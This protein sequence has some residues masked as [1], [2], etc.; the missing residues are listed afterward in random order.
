MWNLCVLFFFGFKFCSPL[1]ISSVSI[2]GLMWMQNQ[3]HLFFTMNSGKLFSFGNADKNITLQIYVI[4]KKINDC[5]I[6]D[7][8]IDLRIDGYFLV[9]HDSVGFVH[10]NDIWNG[11]DIQHFRDNY[12]HIK[13]NK[14][15]NFF[16][17]IDAN[18]VQRLVST[19]K[20]NIIDK[21]CV[22]HFNLLEKYS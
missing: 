8:E 15:C 13:T 20:K 22:E 3:I 17:W 9:Y 2:A 19:E 6:F 10:W 11:W 4:K 21:I 14:W 5:N 1:T 18:F 7:D 12:F 16:K